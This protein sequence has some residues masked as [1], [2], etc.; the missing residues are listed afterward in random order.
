M[1]VAIEVTT[2]VLLVPGLL[3]RAAATV[4][5]GMTTAIEVFVY[6]EA[7]PTRLERRRVLAS[8]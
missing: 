5:L 1:A 6:P 8:G 4:L 7:W 3:K 2:P